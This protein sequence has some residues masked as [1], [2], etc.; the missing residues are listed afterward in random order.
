MLSRYTSE[1]MTEVWSE[2]AA[3]ERWRAVELAVVEARV[4]L[5]EA[6]ALAAMEARAAPAPTVAEVHEAESRTRHDVAAFLEVWTRDM[7]DEAAS[8]IH[9]G[10]TSSDVV[11]TALSLAVR[12]ASQLVLDATNKLIR[13]LAHHALTHRTTKRVGRTHG[14]HAVADVWGHRVADITLAVDRARTRLRRATEAVA[15]A[16]VSGP[17]G[18]Y[19]GVSVEVE[20]QTARLLGLTPVDVATQVILR[21]RLAEWM[22]ALALLAS[23][24]EAFALEVRHGQR[25]E[26]AELAEGVGDRQVGSSAMPHKRN[27]VTAEKICGLARLVRA[28]VLPV[29]EGIALWHERDIS[30]S[31]VERVSLPDSSALAEHIVLHTTSLVELLV[32]DRDRMSELLASARPGID[33]EHGVLTLMAAGMRRET[34]YTIVRELINRGLSTA[35]FEREL[36]GAACAVGL[37]LEPEWSTRSE[38]AP[39]AALAHVFDQVAALLT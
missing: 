11:D 38:S 26:V 5:G 31:S 3:L 22:C 19:A 28:S 21:D 32:V 7:P 17:T 33:S 14:M 24:C 36:E 9:R 13:S 39:N 18:T 37:M 4:F 1:R 10:L 15:L 29:M 27:P 8:W 6:P 25:S 35:D 12:D 20:R 23:T 2:R 34:A 30:H 16:K